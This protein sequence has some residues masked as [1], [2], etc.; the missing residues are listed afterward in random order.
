MRGSR[1]DLRS[2]RDV[3]SAIRM[4]VA[5]STQRR[6]I[7][8]QPAR[9]ARPAAWRWAPIGMSET[10]QTG[11]PWLSPPL[12]VDHGDRATTLPGWPIESDAW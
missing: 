11:G 8:D 12:L 3:T 10:P 7:G 1:T 4:A 5:E 6:L 2:S 9:S